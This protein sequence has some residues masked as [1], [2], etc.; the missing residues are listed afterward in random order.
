MSLTLTLFVVSK[1]RI[2]LAHDSRQATC[3]GSGTCGDTKMNPAA[4]C[5]IAGNYRVVVL[6]ID[7]SERSFLFRFPLGGF[8]LAYLNLV[9]NAGFCRKRWVQNMYSV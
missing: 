9:V 7:V 4:R 1:P 2:R 8:N 6:G 5:E 3:I